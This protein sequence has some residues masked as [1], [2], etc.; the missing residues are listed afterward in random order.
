MQGTGDDRKVAPRSPED[1]KKLQDIV[2]GAVGI[3]TTRGDTIALAEL[4]FNNDFATEVTEELDRQQKTDFWWALA[5]NSIYPALG[6]LALFILLRLFKS[7]PIQEI[8]IGVPVG[9]LIAKHNGN[10]NGH[11]KFGEFEP[12]PG[13]V[14]VEVL[15]RL[16][17]ENPANMT[18]AIRDWM[19]KGRTP[20]Q[21]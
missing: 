9:R 5:R 21:N 15:N 2:V 18:Q 17:K 7:T 8:P 14:T 4:P 20:E 3:D 13:V 11:G 12:Q 19:T 10:G 1:L 6:F 16:I